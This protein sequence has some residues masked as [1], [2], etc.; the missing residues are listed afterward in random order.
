MPA[1]QVLIRYIDRIGRRPLALV[2]LIGM[3]AG[4]LPLGAFYEDVHSLSEPILSKSHPRLLIAGSVER[5]AGLAV[6]F[7]A[8]A[9]S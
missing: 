6:A 8:G 5:G 1:L 7:T 4:L 3:M 9:P 2:G